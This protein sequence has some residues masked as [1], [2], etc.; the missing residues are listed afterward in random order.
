ME[1]LK[2]NKI[3]RAGLLILGVLIV[4]YLAKCYFDKQQVETMENNNNV[5]ANVVNNATNVVNNAAEAVNNAVNNA[6]EVVNNVVNNTNNKKNNNRVNTPES[7]YQL[8][9]SYTSGENQAIANGLTPNNF[10]KP[11][12]VTGSLPEGDESYATVSGNG[13]ENAAVDPTNCHP[14]D[15]L[16]PEDLLPGNSDNTWSQVNPSSQGNLGDQNFLK[17]GYHVGINTVGQ[18]LRNANLQL[19]SDPIISK[20]DIGPWNQSTIEADFGRVPLEHGEK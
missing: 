2:Q 7:T 8:K 14:K 1:G 17:A 20:S 10:S 19:R 5:A 3:L 18:S 13:S 16:S 9:P 15:Q 11:A 12:E 4:V 6:A